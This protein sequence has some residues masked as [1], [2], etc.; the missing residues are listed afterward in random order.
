MSL[1][2][3]VSLPPSLPEELSPA[4]YADWQFRRGRGIEVG[5]QGRLLLRA[6]TLR[7]PEHKD[8]EEKQKFWPYSSGTPLRID[9]IMC[10]Y[11]IQ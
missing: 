5:V 6:N 9:N 1:L 7:R 3:A 8:R 2:P 10:R 11:L 4:G